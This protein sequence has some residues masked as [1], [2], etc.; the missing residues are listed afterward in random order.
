MQLAALWETD[1]L[2]L[3][4]KFAASGNQVTDPMGQNPS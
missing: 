3:S 1:D 4:W 2:I